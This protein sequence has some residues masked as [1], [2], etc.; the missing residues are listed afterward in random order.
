MALFLII[1]KESDSPWHVN[2]NLLCKSTVAEDYKVPSYCDPYQAGGWK[3]PLILI[4]KTSSELY[5]INNHD[6]LVFVDGKA[7]LV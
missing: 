4:W 2:Q 5:I 6:E 7:S 3:I 1:L